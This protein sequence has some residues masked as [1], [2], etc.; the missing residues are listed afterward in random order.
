M[1]QRRF[2]GAIRPNQADA[3]AFRDGEGNIPEERH[4]PVAL[5]EILCVEDGWQAEQRPLNG[6]FEDSRGTANR[7]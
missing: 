2:A 1:Q 5:R 7:D 6:L 4:S 3:I